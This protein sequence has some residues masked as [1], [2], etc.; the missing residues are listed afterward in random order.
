MLYL[1]TLIRDLQAL[2]AL[3]GNVPVVSN[4]DDDGFVAV[5]AEAPAIVE[6]QADEIEDCWYNCPDL[7]AG[8][9]VIQL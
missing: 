7:K 4:S 8:D 3:H 1:S 2:E 9:K 6:V 5:P